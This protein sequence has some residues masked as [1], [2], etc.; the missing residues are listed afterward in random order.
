M[1]SHKW[2]QE[3]HREHRAGLFK[4]VPVCIMCVCVCIMYVSCAAVGMG[5][6]SFADRVDDAST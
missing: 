3:G 2:K 5:G 1:P 4:I 6:F